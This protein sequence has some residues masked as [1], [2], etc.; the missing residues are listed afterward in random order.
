[1]GDVMFLQLFRVLRVDTMG[2]SSVILLN[3]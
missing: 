1:M 2:N 3:V